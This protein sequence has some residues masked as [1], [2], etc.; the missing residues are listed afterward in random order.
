MPD[1]IVRGVHITRPDGDKA[2]VASVKI[3]LGP[4]SGLPIVLAPV[5]DGLGLGIT[6][7]IE[8]GL[9]KPGRVFGLWALLAICRKL[10]QR[11]QATSSA[12]PY[13]PTVMRPV[14][15]LRERQRT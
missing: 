6:E 8:D 9:K 2:D 3:M 12:S 5:N 13:L 15:P 4:A 14:C 11:C 10:P 7:G 1:R